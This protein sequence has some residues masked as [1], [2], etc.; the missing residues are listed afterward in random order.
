MDAV[1]DELRDL[2][3]AD[4]AYLGLLGMNVDIDQAGGEFDKQYGQRIPPALH[5]V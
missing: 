4:K 2:H 5:E 1:E 3:W